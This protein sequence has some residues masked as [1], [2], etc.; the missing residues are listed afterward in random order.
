MR[1]FGVSSLTSSKRV[2]ITGGGDPTKDPIG[3]LN[4]TK[5]GSKILL[6]SDVTLQ[7]ASSTH[8][9]HFILGITTGML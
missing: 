9:I 8:P 4:V 3:S 6:N 2:M 1:M 7:M 5:I